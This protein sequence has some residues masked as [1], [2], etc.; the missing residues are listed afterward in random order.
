[1]KLPGNK[2]VVRPRVRFAGRAPDRTIRD[3]YYCRRNL[4][5]RR[6]RVFIVIVCFLTILHQS[7]RCV[8]A[9]FRYEKK[10]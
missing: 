1:M 5:V 2:Y 4:S 10:K 7:A 6:S 9:T 3:H 8:C